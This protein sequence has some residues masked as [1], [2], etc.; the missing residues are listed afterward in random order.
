MQT[1]SYSLMTKGPTVL[2]ETTRLIS[3]KFTKR[4]RICE[5]KNFPMASVGKCKRRARQIQRATHLSLDVNVSERFLNYNLTEY[6][7][8][9]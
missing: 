5:E 6:R 2:Q 8:L 3:Q 9:N 4:F 7:K 1:T